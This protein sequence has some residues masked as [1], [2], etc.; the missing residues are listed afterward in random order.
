M[1]F[2]CAP[3][4]KQCPSTTRK[5][6][7]E[8]RLRKRV[9]LRLLSFTFPFPP[10]HP[11]PPRH[12]SA[13]PVANRKVNQQAQKTANVSSF[14]RH[15]R[16]RQAPRAEPAHRFGRP[17]WANLVEI[18]PGRGIDV[19]HHLPTTDSASSQLMYHDSA[20]VHHEIAPEHSLPQRIRL[21][22]FG[23]H[24]RRKWFGHLFRRFAGRDGSGLL[25]I[26]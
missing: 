11:P 26:L 15:S 16:K 13:D 19:A 6:P 14:G 2:A 1:M 9:C 10:A 20:L 4:K 22:Q 12:D 24:G 23:S 5:V 7:V 25:A 17:S 21:A 18:L 8:G 3:H